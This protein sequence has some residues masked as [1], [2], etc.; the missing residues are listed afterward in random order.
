MPTSGPSR[1]YGSWRSLQ[2][3]GDTFNA[4]PAEALQLALHPLEIE[5]FEEVRPMVDHCV[6]RAL[7][8]FPTVLHSWR[9]ALGPCPCMC[10]PQDLSWERLCKDGICSVVLPTP[11]VDFS[12][13]FI[14]LLSGLSPTLPMGSD[15]RLALALLEQLAFPLQSSWILGALARR[16]AEQGVHFAR[17]LDPIQIVLHT[18]RRLLLRDAEMLP[19]SKSETPHP[20]T[21]PNPY[22]VLRVFREGPGSMVL[23]T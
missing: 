11:G 16:L 2:D 17:S 18:Q 5:A 12:T 6:R 14:A 22:I 20:R 9:S 4:A 23:R 19:N 13:G 15:A 7:Q 10:R 8:A 1:P 3:L 21:A